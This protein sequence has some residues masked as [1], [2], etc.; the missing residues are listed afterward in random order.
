MNNA[1]RT[2]KRE[3]YAGFLLA[4]AVGKSSC[5]E[6]R[7]AGMRKRNRGGKRAGEKQTGKQTRR[8]KVKRR[9]GGGKDGKGGKQKAGSND[10]SHRVTDGR[11]ILPRNL[12]ERGGS[13]PRDREKC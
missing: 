2:G 7:N 10:E 3:N 5:R 9:S 1:W 6:H 11:T 4:A 8:R 13:R 12:F